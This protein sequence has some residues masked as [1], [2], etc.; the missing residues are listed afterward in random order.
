MMSFYSFG[1]EN[2]MTKCYNN[3][4]YEHLS[5]DHMQALFRS[6]SVHANKFNQLGIKNKQSSTAQPH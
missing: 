2:G 1:F 3:H 6:F 5:S 4:Q